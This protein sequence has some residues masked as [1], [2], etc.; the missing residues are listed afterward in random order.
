[1]APSLVEHHCLAV[2]GRRRVRGRVRW[3]VRG[4][5]SPRA[6]RRRA[7]VDQ[8]REPGGSRGARRPGARCDRRP[9][10]AKH[11]DVARGT[12]A[13]RRHAPGRWRRC[14]VGRGGGRRRGCDDVR[15][16]V[17][18]DADTRWPRCRDA[19]RPGSVVERFADAR[20]GAARCTV[21]GRI[22]HPRRPDHVLP[23]IAARRDR[24]TLR[25]RGG[26]G[27][28]SSRM[29]CAGRRGGAL[30]ER[31]GPVPVRP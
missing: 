20:R 21:P 25:D 26:V 17:G 6:W 15:C 11:P 29:R 3:C 8:H 1:M 28:R 2:A 31:R 4:G 23:D 16:H 13:G 19:R 9:H 12:N 24:R 30:D 7:R 18:R 10:G 5:V 14:S 22:C 27:S